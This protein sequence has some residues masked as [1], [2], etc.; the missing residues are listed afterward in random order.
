MEPLLTRGR[1]MSQKHV[2]I[3]AVMFLCKSRVK[4]II[5]ERVDR[6]TYGHLCLRGSGSVWMTVTVRVSRSSKGDFIPV[7]GI[8]A[9]TYG[10]IFEHPGAI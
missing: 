2:T 10:F 5:F 8:G 9:L 7:T 1:V 3:I 4:Q 6:E